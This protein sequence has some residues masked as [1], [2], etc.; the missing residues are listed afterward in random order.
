MLSFL[1]GALSPEDLELLCIIGAGCLP[2]FIAL[3]L[4]LF[5]S[6]LPDE[7]DIPSRGRPINQLVHHDGGVHDEDDWRDAA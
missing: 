5:A 7:G 2:S 4:A 1:T 6:F 3:L